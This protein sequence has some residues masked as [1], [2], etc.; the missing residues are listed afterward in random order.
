MWAMQQPAPPPAAKNGIVQQWFGRIPRPLSGFTPAKGYLTNARDL[1]A[2]WQ[3]WGLKADVPV[4]DFDKHIVIVSTSRS[5]TFQVA[6]IQVDATGDMKTVIMA[7]PDMRGDVAFVITV[8]ER[9]GAKTFHGAPI[10]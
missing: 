10:Q 2:L 3:N 4:I 7:S 6:A 8:A 9:K 5:S 1:A